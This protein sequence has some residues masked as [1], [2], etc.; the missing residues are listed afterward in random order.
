MTQL[1]EQLKAIK[2]LEKSVENA[3]QIAYADKETKIRFG[4][5]TF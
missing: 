5:L 2:I 3:M 4:Y 1:K